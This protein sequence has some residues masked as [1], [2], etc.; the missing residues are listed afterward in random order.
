[1]L[2]SNSA[3]GFPWLKHLENQCYLYIGEILA[4][5]PEVEGFRDQGFCGFLKKALTSREEPD[6]SLSIVNSKARLTCL[7]SRVTCVI[8]ARSTVASSIHAM[9]LYVVY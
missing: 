9:I 3:A 5:R 7:Y 8:L 4:A 1:M 6:I 2:I